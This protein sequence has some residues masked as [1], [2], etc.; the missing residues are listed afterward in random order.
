MTIGPCR[1]F[2]RTA[3]E[4]VDFYGGVRIHSG[5]ISFHRCQLYAPYSTPGVTIVD[6]D[7]VVTECTVAGGPPQVI[8]GG[9]WPCSIANGGPG[10]VMQQG[11]LTIGDCTVLDPVGFNGD[12]D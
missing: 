8:G 12:C 6:G 1:L 3:F 5:E 2:R 7:V 4:D 9:L 11:T 10:I